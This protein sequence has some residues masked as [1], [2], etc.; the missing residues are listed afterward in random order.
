MSRV[1]ITAVAAV[2]AVAVAACGVGSS[3]NTEAVLERAVI[4]G[5]L[6]LSTAEQVEVCRYLVFDSVDPPHGEIKMTQIAQDASERGTVVPFNSRL[7]D[8]YDT[9]TAPGIPEQVRSAQA[10]R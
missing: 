4:D 7:I 2:A 10:S 8:V 5:M 6:T 1:L 3:I 9:C